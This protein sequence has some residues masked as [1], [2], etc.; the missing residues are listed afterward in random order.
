L[1]VVLATT[2]TGPI[3]EEGG[4]VAVMLEFELIRN[5][6]AGVAPKSTTLVRPRLPP[7]MVT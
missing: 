4:A 6:G 7:V 3:V 5:V 2:L 1:T